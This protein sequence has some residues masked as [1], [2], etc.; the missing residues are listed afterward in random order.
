[1]KTVFSQKLTASVA[2]VAVMSSL[3]ACAPQGGYGGGYGGGYLPPVNKQ[4]VGGVLGGVGGAVAGAQFGKGNG[5]VASAALGTLL[6]A[7][8]GSEVGKSLD[9]ADMGYANEAAN[10][11]FATGQGMR[12]NNPESGNA[13]TIEPIR[14]Y[15]SS[16]GVCREFEQT[17]TI[18][19]RSE[20]AYGTACKQADG[21]WKIQN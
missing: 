11:S 2:L 3:S 14:S 19:G 21:T 8:I 17:V 6:G 18:A 1:M 7:F 13:G 4:T 9:R 10:R 12:W 16:S 20:R 15:Q 5:R